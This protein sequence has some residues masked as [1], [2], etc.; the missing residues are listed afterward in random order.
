MAAPALE[1]DIAA[2][3]HSSIA[4]HSAAAPRS[5]LRL[6]MRRSATSQGKAKLPCSTARGANG[7]L[8]SCD[9]AWRRMDQ[10]AAKRLSFDV[11]QNYPA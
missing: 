7:D 10:N 5:R 1:L 6:S 4:P 11:I 8:N 2:G 3:I 9:Q